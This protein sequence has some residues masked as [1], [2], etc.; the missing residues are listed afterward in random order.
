MR[1]KVSQGIDHGVI[2]AGLAPGL[3]QPVPVGLDID[4]LQRVSGYELQVHQ[5]VPRF[6]KAGD[7]AARVQ[8]EM[9][10]AL[11]ADLQVSF[12]LGLEDVLPT[13]LALLPQTLSANTL[14]CC[15]RFNLVFLPLKPGHVFPSSTRPRWC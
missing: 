1:A 10:S 7:A 14:F 2:E 4:K 8:P 12:E 3:F 9:V 15:I 11:G 13:A 5:L 6:Q